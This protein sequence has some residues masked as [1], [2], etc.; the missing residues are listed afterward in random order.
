MTCEAY[1]Q[2][3]K[4][5]QH[6]RSEYSYFACAENRTLRQISDRGLAHL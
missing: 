5:W 6:A 1:D 4:D 3:E 2:L